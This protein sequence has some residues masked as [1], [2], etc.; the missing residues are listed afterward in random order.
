MAAADDVALD[1]LSASW[2][3]DGA[4]GNAKRNVELLREY[5]SRAEPSATHRVDLRL[6]RSPVQ[7]LGDERGRVRALRVVRTR[8]ERLL[9][10]PADGG[11]AGGTEG[12]LREGVPALVT[13]A[14]WAA[15]D[16]HER[17]AGPAKGR[18][19]VKLVRVG[20][21]ARIANAGAA[22]GQ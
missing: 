16:A 22:A 5:T 14:G 13:W 10:D 3:E 9:R 4:G 19:R 1:P 11:D 8:I 21:L 17:S 2:L 18:P 15:I 20:D 12:W 6:L 7:T